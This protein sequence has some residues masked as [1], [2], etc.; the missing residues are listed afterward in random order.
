[1]EHAPQYPAVPNGFESHLEMSGEPWG[2]MSTAWLA[3]RQRAPC[4]CTDAHGCISLGNEAIDGVTHRDSVAELFGERLLSNVLAIAPFPTPPPFHRARLSLLSTW[5]LPPT[6]P[7]GSCSPGPASAPYGGGYRS[8]NPELFRGVGRGF[9]WPGMVVRTDRE[10]TE[11]P[12]RC[13][14]KLCCCSIAVG[15]MGARSPPA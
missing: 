13:L 7:R 14:A 3:Q 2:V 5:W 15:V 12:G 1:M 9:G 10:R 4:S 6:S 11:D 8:L